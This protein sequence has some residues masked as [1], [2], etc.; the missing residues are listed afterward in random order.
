MK[1]REKKFL[2]RPEYPGGKEAFRQ[3]V[4][5]NLKYPEEA[6]A[7]GIG[8]IVYLSARIDDNG[9]VSDVEV[10]KGI[11]GGC[12]EEAVRLISS[13]HFGKVK[14]RG[15]RVSTRKKFRIEFRLPPRM[16]YTGKSVRQATGSQTV[17]PIEAGGKTPQN[18]SDPE[19]QIHGGEPALQSPAGETDREN[20]PNDISSPAITYQVS[21]SKKS[22]APA[23]PAQGKKKYTYTIRIKP[24]E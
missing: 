10:E 14:N 9:E 16:V 1:H 22:Q 5:S 4:K 8:G 17:R 19:M 6:L 12:D 15:L 23:A 21:P 11:G 2:K 18:P 24:R 7:K 3:Y 13:V 20:S